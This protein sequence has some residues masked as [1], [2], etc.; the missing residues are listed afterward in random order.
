[1]A[2]L[3]GVDRV[4]KTLMGGVSSG[5]NGACDQNQITSFGVIGCQLVS[6][7]EVSF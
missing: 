5:Q 2:R 3:S 1:M 6:R 7:A 4:D